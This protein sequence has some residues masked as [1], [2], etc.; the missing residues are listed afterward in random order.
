MSL[1]EIHW[2]PTSCQAPDIS[3]LL[4]D[5]VG[6]G[7]MKKFF[8]AAE[9]HEPKTR[10]L[11]WGYLRLV[12]KCTYEYSRGRELLQAFV[13]SK[14]S[15]DRIGIM[16]HAANHFETCIGSLHR[17][18]KYLEALRR[19]RTGPKIP[20][21]IAVLRDIGRIRNVRDAIEHTDEDIWEQ[22]ISLGDPHVLQ[23][24]ETGLALR[25]EEI[26]YQELAKWIQDLHEQATL[27]AEH[28]A[29]I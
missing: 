22:R 4:S 2:K 28:G 5:L 9:S 18:A 15:E 6:E 23:V 13:S 29:N 17:A 10:A 27:I 19:D 24:K 20:R 11:R 1:S 3:L 8:H 21:N 7:I 12:D 25:K 26:S 14:P 16:L